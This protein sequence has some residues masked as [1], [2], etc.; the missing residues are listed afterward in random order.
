MRGQIKKPPGTAGGFLGN[1]R[2]P[3]DATIPFLRQR[4]WK[5]KKAEKVRNRVHASMLAHAGPKFQAGFSHPFAR[6]G[7]TRAHSPTLSL[8]I[9]GSGSTPCTGC[10]LTTSRPHPAA[11]S[12]KSPSVVH[13][14]PPVTPGTPSQY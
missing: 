9:P 7:G 6:Q 8:C 2:L 13:V 1:F 4:H 10:V 12:S 3:V 5:R 11:A 14:R